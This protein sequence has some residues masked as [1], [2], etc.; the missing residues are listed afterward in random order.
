MNNKAVINLI[1]TNSVGKP[2]K[3]SKIMKQPLSWVCWWI[4][5]RRLNYLNSKRSTFFIIKQKKSKDRGLEV[6]T[7]WWSLN[8]RFQRKNWP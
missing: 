8:K 6:G 7:K 2:D 4:D 3:L 5:F 1:T